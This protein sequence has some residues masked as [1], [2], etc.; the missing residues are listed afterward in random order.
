VNSPE[1]KRNLNQGEE[2]NNGSNQPPFGGCDTVL[3]CTVLYMQVQSQGWAERAERVEGLKGRVK[4]LKGSQCPYGSQLSLESY[5]TDAPPPP[6]RRAMPDAASRARSTAAQGVG[7]PIR[8]CYLHS[9]SS[10]QM[11]LW[12][13]NHHCHPHRVHYH[14]HYHYHPH[15]KYQPKRHPLV[16]SLFPLTGLGVCTV[17]DDESAALHRDIVKLTWTTAPSGRR[18]PWL[19]GTGVLACL[20]IFRVAGWTWLGAA[21]TVNYNN[22]QSD[23]TFARE[24]RQIRNELPHL[25]ARKSPHSFT[26]SAYDNLAC[27][28]S[29]HGPP[30]WSQLSV[31]GFF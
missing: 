1:N 7:Q 13:I 20:R 28:D 22:L 5:L 30:E 16:S 17:S 10:L 29:N 9:V 14:D 23:N 12:T 4:A 3:Y 19:P 24:H 6:G 31:Q 18:P 21:S 2:L 26:A 27:Q 8:V 11:P 15:Q 25:E